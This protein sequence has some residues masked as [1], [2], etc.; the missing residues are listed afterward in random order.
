[1]KTTQT[2]STLLEAKF[3]SVSLHICGSQWMLW[4]PAPSS[5]IPPLQYP[6]PLLSSST[7]QNMLMRCDAWLWLQGSG[8]LIWSG[9]SVSYREKA[10]SDGWEGPELHF[11]FFFLTALPGCFFWKGL[12]VM[13][14]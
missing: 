12:P 4:K 10:E 6:E 11:L 2:A 14:V 7:A 8:S 9:W 1:M 5:I 13:F 3:H